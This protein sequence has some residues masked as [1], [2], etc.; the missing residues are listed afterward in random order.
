MCLSFRTYSAA[1]KNFQSLRFEIYDV[2]RMFADVNTE[3]ERVSESPQ[4]VIIKGF[5]GFCSS[6]LNMA[7]NYSFCVPRLCVC[8]CVCVHA[9]I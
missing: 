9:R 4:W 1:F 6:G 2:L 5:T 8:V 3:L 7:S